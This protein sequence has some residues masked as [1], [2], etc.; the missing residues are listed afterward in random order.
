MAVMRSPAGGPC[1]NH[2]LSWT[3]LARDNDVYV[4]TIVARAVAIQL[5]L[6][7][8]RVTLSND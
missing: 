8:H 1:P 7:E 3:R 6:P 5:N 2:D 4:G